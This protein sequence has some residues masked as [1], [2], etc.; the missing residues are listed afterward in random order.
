MGG[1]FRLLIWRLQFVNY[2]WN[3][4]NYRTKVKIIKDKINTKSERED[5]FSDSDALI[6]SYSIRTRSYVFFVLFVHVLSYSV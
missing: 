2:L 6:Q 4:I 3:S 5:E 1:K